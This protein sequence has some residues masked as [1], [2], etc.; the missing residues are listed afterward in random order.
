[1]KHISGENLGGKRPRL[2]KS[3]M[4]RKRFIHNILTQRM[5]KRLG[6]KTRQRN[7]I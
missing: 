2:Q 3:S 6:V 5:G 4:H 1:M 7:S